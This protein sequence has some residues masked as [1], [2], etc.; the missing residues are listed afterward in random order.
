MIFYTYIPIE[1]IRIFVIISLIINEFLY[2]EVQIPCG[3]LYQDLYLR[4]VSMDGVFE[5][6]LS[7]RQR[8]FA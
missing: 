5:Q 1:H 2:G 7:Q 6:R 8:V 3:F 4:A